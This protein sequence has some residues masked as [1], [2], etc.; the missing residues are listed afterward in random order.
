MNQG[1]GCLL[2][3]V[4][5]LLS[6]CS[7]SMDSAPSLDTNDPLGTLDPLARVAFS[8]NILHADSRLISYSRQAG[9]LSI[10]DPLIPAEVWG[11]NYPGYHFA[12]AHTDLQ[13]ASLFNASSIS[14]VAGS[15][16]REFTLQTSYG[17]VASA[18]NKVAYSLAALDGRSIE[19][20]RTLGSGQWQ[21]ETLAI[22]WADTLAA[23]LSA[24]P[25]TQ[26]VLL[27]SVFDADA[28]FLLAISPSDGRYTVYAA[29]SGNQA[30]SN[31]GAW[32][33]GNGSGV[34]DDASFYAMA[35]DEQLRVLYLGDKQGRVFVIPAEGACAD[36]ATLPQ[37]ALA[38]T[39]EVSRI[40]VY[41]PGSIGVSQR[42]GDLTVLSFADTVFN[43]TSETYH[44]SCEVPLGSIPIGSEHILVYCTATEVTE[45]SIASEAGPQNPGID[46]HR[47]M[48]IEKATGDITTYFHSGLDTAG[49]AI[50][51]TSGKL[52]RVR[53]GAFG[54]FESL[55]LVSGT[56]TGHKGLFIHGMLNP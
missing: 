31:G 16:R 34:P 55:D 53:E 2:F 37:Y 28:N 13:G 56:R 23:D 54:R 4:I 35:W 30:L 38:Q 39:H 11:A 21:H 50:D 51:S 48:L 17:H 3:T 41:A 40:S 45:E 42:H 24:P 26:P 27:A 46:P 18:G 1:T 29:G 49:L 44:S 22:P 12:V 15:E 33:S 5:C 8:G 14:V 9:R 36:W 47:Y 10:I 43:S 6:A 32:C 52:Y 7:A 20:L 19:V 25:A